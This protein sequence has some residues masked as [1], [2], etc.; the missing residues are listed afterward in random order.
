[1]RPGEP[2]DPTYGL[3]YVTVASTSAGVTGSHAVIVAGVAAA[4]FY[5][6]P[7]WRWLRRALA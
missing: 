6:A 3:D 7:A 2:T 1:M 4:V 5:G